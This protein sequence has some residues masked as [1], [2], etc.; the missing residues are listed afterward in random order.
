MKVQSLKNL[1]YATR[2]YVNK[3]I[4]PY[5]QDMVNDIGWQTTNQ[6][7]LCGHYPVFFSLSEST[8]EAQEGPDK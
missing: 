8:Y 6:T 7:H 3:L 4:D 5:T 2:P 1:L